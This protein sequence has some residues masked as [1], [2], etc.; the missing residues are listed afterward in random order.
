[1][2]IISLKIKKMSPQLG[3]ADIKHAVEFY[4]NVLGF[5]LDFEYEDF[6]A[7]ISKDGFSIHLKSGISSAEE[8][9]RNKENEALE[10]IFSVE[11]VEDLYNDLLYK[12]IAITQALRKQPYGKEFYI[13]D[14]DGNIL[15]FMEE[16]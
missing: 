12:S 14:P 8:S 10:I 16:A 4:T 7:G 9:K 13:A 15:A 3:V 11:R 2:P 1:M 6:Y 5:D